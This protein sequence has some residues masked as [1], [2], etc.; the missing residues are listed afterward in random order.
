MALHQAL[1][2]YAGKTVLVTGHTGFKGSWLVQ[3]LHKLGARVVGYALPPEGS[4]PL[5]EVLC[6]AKLC[7]PHVVGDITNRPL[8]QEVVK[9]TQPDFVFHL[10]AQ[11]LVRRSY[12]EPLATWQVN[13][14]GTAHVLE[15]LRLLAKPCA[16][17]VITT[18]KVYENPEDAHA[19]QETDP[20]GGYDPYSASKAAAE[21]VAA[22]YRRS[23][24]APDAFGTTH[25]VALASARSGNVIGG[26]DTAE[27][28]LL[29]DLFRALAKSEALQLRSPASTRPW[30]HVLEPLTGYLQLALKLQEAP[31]QYGKAYNFGPDASQEASVEAVIQ[32]AIRMYGSGT[33][34]ALENPDGLHEAQRLQLD[35]TRARHE[36]GWK[37]RYTW[38]EAV[39]LTVAWQ[40]SDNKAQAT[41]DQLTAYLA[42]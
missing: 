21:L 41:H 39:A 38:Q 36:L 40:Q 10:A 20:L 37:Q 35:S 28:R 9:D 23:F 42:S 34:E 12:R 6:N 30:Q 8:L 26:G 15:A 1:A 11:S 24:F 16:A 33:Y 25:H 22:S 13:T 2:G 3:L 17:L 29:P 18:D 5:F 31:T 7:E 4:P 19:F 32:E 27:D 14:L